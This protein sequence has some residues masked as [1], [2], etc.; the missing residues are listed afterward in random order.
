MLHK[1]VIFLF[2]GLFFSISEPFAPGGLIVGDVAI[3]SYTIVTTIFFLRKN[4]QDE[5]R[6]LL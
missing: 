3:V 6:N 4:W 5:N 1:P 2:L